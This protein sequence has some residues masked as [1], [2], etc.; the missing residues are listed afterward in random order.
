VISLLAVACGKQKTPV[1]RTNEGGSGMQITPASH[2]DTETTPVRVEPKVTTSV[3]FKDGESAFHA[4]QYDEAVKA[5][6]GYT[7]T[8][9]ENP[10][11]HY[12]LGLS[13]WKSKDLDQAEGE[14]LKV[15]ELDPSHLK[16]RLNLARVYLDK[17]ELDKSMEQIESVLKVDSFN[18]EG[19]RLLGRVSEE[20][21]KLVEAEQAYRQA[22]KLDGQ[23]SWSMNNL[24]LVLIKQ[25]RADESIGMLA[26]AVEIKP[27][28]SR[29]QN[30][31]GMSLE[32]NG[33]FTG[34]AKAYQTAVELDGSY[35]KAIDNLARVTGRADKTEFNLAELAQNFSTEIG[36]QKVSRN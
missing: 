36:A 26:R 12:M 32:L 24:G 35:Q 4:G 14:F 5:F 11:G 2:V 15:I 33:Y 18:V 22:L 17:G 8:K 25:K 6:K 29:F 34:A 3:S 1:A 10:W 27:E 16:S 20:Q 19:F 21:D 7:G 23:D 31:L 9:P 13:A 28:N 30:N